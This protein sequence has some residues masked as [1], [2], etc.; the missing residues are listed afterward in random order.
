V[1]NELVNHIVWAGFSPEDWER[2]QHEVSNNIDN[3]TKV[4]WSE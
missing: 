1:A 2:I 3:R 4:V